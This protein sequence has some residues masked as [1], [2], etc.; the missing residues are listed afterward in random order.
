M[1]SQSEKTI[2]SKR[3]YEVSV[4]EKGDTVYLMTHRQSFSR[5]GYLILESFFGGGK[6]SS[7][8][9]YF[10]ENKKL[11]KSYSYLQGNDSIPYRIDSIIRKQENNIIYTI[12]YYSEKA[13][14]YKS[15][16][17]HD[18]TIEE[19]DSS[20][21]VILKVNIID[22]W[23]YDKTHCEFFEYDT[24]NRVTKK[25]TVY[26]CEDMR[27]NFES[28]RNDNEKSGKIK[29]NYFED[30]RVKSSDNFIEIYYDDKNRLTRKQTKSLDL[31]FTYSEDGKTVIEKGNRGYDVY[32]LYNEN[33]DLIEEYQL[34]PK[35]NKKY[36]WKKY[37][38]MYF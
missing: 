13:E 2:K 19:L 10:Y 27:W 3:T 21:N 24:L 9:L 15:G 20:G 32:Y 12:N 34:K 5:G 35:D 16:Q 31:T 1:F 26:H 38:Y 14:N 8:T 23:E 6:E 17:M 36:N 25:I 29:K 22:K 30:K 4:N 7:K 28:N 11:F 18:E 37:D 33:D